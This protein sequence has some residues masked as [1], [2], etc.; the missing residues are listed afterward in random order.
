MRDAAELMAR[1]QASQAPG[2]ETNP[3][4]GPILAE[5]SEETAG[6]MDA[7]PSE[8]TAGDTADEDGDEDGEDEDD[9]RDEEE[10]KNKFA[11]I[12]VAT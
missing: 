11:N 6:E 8:D 4:E 12:H 3:T 1:F 5:G 10:G 7:G 9:E 2:D